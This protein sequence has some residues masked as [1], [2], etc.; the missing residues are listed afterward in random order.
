MK[1][2]ATSLIS[3]Y[4]VVDTPRFPLAVTRGCGGGGGPHRHHRNLKTT[5]LAC[6]SPQLRCLRVGEEGV[7]YNIIV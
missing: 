1:S 3:S 7:V 6:L 2:A 4:R 5:D